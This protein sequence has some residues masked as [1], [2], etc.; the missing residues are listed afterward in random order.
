MTWALHAI[1]SWHVILCGINIWPLIITVC[2][3]YRLNGWWLYNV[4]AQLISA[5]RVFWTTQLSWERRAVDVAFPLRR[6][7]EAHEVSTRCSTSP[8]RETKWQQHQQQVI[9]CMYYWEIALLAWLGFNNNNNN[10]LILICMIYKII[11]GDLFWKNNGGKA[12]LNRCQGYIP[13][14]SL[15]VRPSNMRWYISACS[16]GQSGISLFPWDLNWLCCWRHEKDNCKQLRCL[17]LC[18]VGIVQDTKSPPNY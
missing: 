15:N 7:T 12:K 9:K 8:K 17:S 10:L 5:C 4:N 6:L 16:A 11:R 2:A 1:F 13:I 18:G 3:P 14:F